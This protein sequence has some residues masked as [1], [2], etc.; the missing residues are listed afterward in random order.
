M[1]HIQSLLPEYAD[2]PVSFVSINTRN[3]KGQVDAELKRFRKQY[4]LTYP[5]YYGRGR[6]VNKDFKVKVL[7]RLILVR[8]D[9]TV[10]KDV[11][12]LKAPALK[13]EIDKLL[14]ELPPQGDEHTSDSE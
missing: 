14:D 4:K 1:P 13:T 5:A 3:P 7:P 12:F 8:P 11:M 9:S 10:Y 2:K 6:N